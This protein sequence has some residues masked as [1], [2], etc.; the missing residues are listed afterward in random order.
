MKPQ[1]LFWTTAPSPAAACVPAITLGMLSVEPEGWNEVRC[2]LAPGATPC[3]PDP[4]LLP[5]ATE[6]TKV[7]CD[8]SGKVPLV[9]IDLPANSVW[10]RR[11]PSSTMAIS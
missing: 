5:A 1:E 11:K 8:S 6:A 2:R 10:V 9:V 7:P 4:F 3:M